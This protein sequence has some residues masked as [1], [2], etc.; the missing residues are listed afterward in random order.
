MGRLDGK[1]AIVTGAAMGNGAGIA[2]VLAREG[3]W[4]F[5]CDMQEKVHETAQ[6]L[7]QRGDRAESLVVD[8]SDYYQVQET[9]K[10]VVERAKRIDVLVNNAGVIRLVP[11][12]EMSDEVRD[13]IFAVNIL[14]VW[15]CCKAVLPYMVAQKYGRIVNMSSVTGPMVVD[16]GETA[17]ATSKAAVWGLTKA[18]AI[19][20]APHNITVNAVCPG[21]ILTPMVRQ[22]A[23]ESNP[24]R[25]QAVIDGIAR[26]IPTGRLGT[27]EEVGDLVAFLA[28]DDAK[29]LTGTQVVI[30]GGSTLP[31]TFG[32]VGV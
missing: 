15:N 16:V 12:L 14:G 20:F 8:V 3:A 26:A 27:P 29:Y 5:L 6:E 17:Y 25:P 18:L 32:A 7:R 13:R 23:A 2:G 24:E 10:R 4:V 28:S 21:Y 1:V 9:V 22:I 30:D 11:F 31:E 19:E